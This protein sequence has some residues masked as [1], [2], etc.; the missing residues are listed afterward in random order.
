MRFQ[1][2]VPRTIMHFTSVILIFL[3]CCAANR[4]K[5]A[6]SEAAPQAAVFRK[7]RRFIVESYYG[8]A[9]IA[10][11]VWGRMAS[12]RRLLIGLRIFAL[13]CSTTEHM[14]L[15][16]LDVGFSEAKATSGV[17]TLVA[18]VIHVGRATGAAV[19][20]RRLLENISMA[21]VVAIDA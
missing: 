18:G 13:C 10:T 11:S 7:E 16:G 20:R 21:D 17:A 1:S 14:Q 8:P 9:R 12:C 15:I 4:S 19:S 5:A 6:G 2:Q 3:R